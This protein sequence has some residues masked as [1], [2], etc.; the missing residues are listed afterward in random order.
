MN[1]KV[2]IGL[3]GGVDSTIAALLLKQQGYDVTG[4]HFHFSHEKYNERVSKVAQ[5]LDIPLINLMIDDDFKKVKQHFA[6]EYLQGRT[7]SPCTFCNKHIKWKK[8]LE[9]ANKNKYEFISSGHYIRKINIDGF[10]YLKKGIDPVKDQSYFLW[11]LESDT[12]KRM[13]TPLGDYTKDEVRQLAKENGFEDFAR[14]KESMGVCFLHNKDYREFLND[15]VPNQL[16]N[17]KPGIVRDE[18]DRIIGTHE[19]FVYYTIGQK[20]DLQ[21]TINRP[22]YVSEI[23]V[24]KNELKVGTK[25]SLYHRHIL[26]NNIHLLNPGVISENSSIHINIRGLGINPSRPAIVKSVQTEMMELELPDA[27]WA[28]APGQPVV[29][30]DDDILLGG[31]IAVKSWS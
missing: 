2:V 25:P 31:G 16:E 15:Y 10:D 22:A 18:N 23:N 17:I 9:F 11:E 30:Y 7:P 29:F 13:I 19:G 24:T 4:L 5:K 3:S 12:I 20:R 14:Q 8:L 28:V 1:K 26:L 27:A 6:Y 21:L